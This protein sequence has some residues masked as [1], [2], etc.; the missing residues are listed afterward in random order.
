MSV[1]IDDVRRIAALARLDPDES[2]LAA[3]AAELNSI[4]G[5]MEVLGK[6]DTSGVPDDDVAARGSMPLRP[7]DGSPVPLLKPLHSFAPA[8]RDSFFIVPRLATHE[9]EDE[10]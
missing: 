6:V 8:I 10:G 7:D 4:L 9:E 1:S 5:H 3:L 2:R